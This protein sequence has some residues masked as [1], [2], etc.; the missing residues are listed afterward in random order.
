MAATLKGMAFPCPACKT[1]MESVDF[2]GIVL[3]ACPKC[4]GV[5]FDDVE[6]RELLDTDPQLLTEL[7]NRLSAPSEPA[8]TTQKRD[9]PHGH[10]MLESYRLLVDSPVVVDSCPMCY[11]VFID[12]DEMAEISE[13]VRDVFKGRL[14]DT[15]EGRR[16][17]AGTTATSLGNQNERDFTAGIAYALNHWRNQ[18]AIEDHGVD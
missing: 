3:Q 13:Y 16:E 11:G 8:P 14:V 12:N 9:C 1:E 6:L 5:W 15:A 18:R 17:R 4:A 2:K 7:D 10:T